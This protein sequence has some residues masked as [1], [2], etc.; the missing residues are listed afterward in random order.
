MKINFI[1]TIFCRLFWSL[2]IF[3]V[4]IKEPKEKDCCMRKIVLFIFLLFSL[5]GLN[6]CE[7]VAQAVVDT[8]LG[9]EECASPGC[10]RDKSAGSSYCMMH[11]HSGGYEVPQDLNKN[12]NQSIS[13]QLN[14]YRE[15]QS[16]LNTKKSSN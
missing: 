15:S 5:L 1:N 13:K 4:S 3:A 11:S 14:E 12:V 2:R 7:T 16:R 6:S 9:R 8:V 10:N